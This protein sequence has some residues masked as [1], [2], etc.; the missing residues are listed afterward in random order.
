VLSAFETVCQEGDVMTDL[1]FEECTDLDPSGAI[2]QCRRQRSDGSAIEFGRLHFDHTTNLY[3]IE[4][5]DGDVSTETYTSWGNAATAL[6]EHSRRLWDEKRQQL[7][8]DL[9]ECEDTLSLIGHPPSLAA[10]RR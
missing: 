10:R 6:L 5:V 3:R 9:A 1:A 7:L 2:S 8:Q 4:P